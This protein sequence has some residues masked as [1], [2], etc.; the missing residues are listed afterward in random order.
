LSAFTFEQVMKQVKAK[1]VLGL[2]ATP[3]RKDGTIPS[4]TWSAGRFDS[5]SARVR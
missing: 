5:S 4:S 1:Y 3:E 2:T